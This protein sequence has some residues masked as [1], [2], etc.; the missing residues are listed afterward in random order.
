MDISTST[1]TEKYYENR[2]ICVE[3]NSNP[4][5]ESDVVLRYSVLMCL[6]KHCISFYSEVRW[7]MQQLCIA[8]DRHSDAVS[9]NDRNFHHRD[10]RSSSSSSSRGD[11]VSKLHSIYVIAALA[12]YTSIVR[13]FTRAPVLPRDAYALCN[14]SY[15]LRWPGVCPFLA[16]RCFLVK[17]KWMELIF[18]TDDLHSAYSIREFV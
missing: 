7:H 8:L 12:S 18:G 4:K 17:A 10:S 15:A 2:F 11:Q 1:T 14:A 3:V 6:K 16:C 5:V 9:H 13:R